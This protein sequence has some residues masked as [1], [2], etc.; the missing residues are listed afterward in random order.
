MPAERILV[1]DFD[2]HHGNSTQE[3]FYDNPQVLYTSTHEYPFYP[4][5]GSRE[6]IGIGAAKGTTINIPLSA[7][8]GDAEY[9]QVF[10]QI[11]ASAARRFNPQLI[12]VSAGYDSHWADDLALM[13]V[14]TTGLLG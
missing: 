7:G 5:T 4:G 14:S 3:T 10:N 1:V 11:I 13:Q 8:C 2:V 9:L 6:E 12:M